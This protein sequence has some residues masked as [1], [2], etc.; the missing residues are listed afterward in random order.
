MIRIKY[1]IHRHLER[2][3][4][5]LDIRRRITP[6]DQVVLCQRGLGQHGL[7]RPQDV[8]RFTVNNRR[9]RTV[10]QVLRFEAGV[11]A[12]GSLGFDDVKALYFSLNAEYRRNAVWLMSEDTTLHLRTLKDSAGAY[13]WRDSDDTILGKP[14]YTSPYMPEIGAGNNPVLF[15]DFSFYWLMERGGVAL[16]PL[17]EKYAAL[18]VTGFIGAEFIDGRLIRRAAVKAVEIDT[19]PAV[20]QNLF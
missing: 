2:L 1:A 19:A 3:F 9:G 11:T 10:K 12:T 4:A 17:R 5:A 15:G 20:T 14:V 16:K 6:P 7:I 18:G 8:H 13:I